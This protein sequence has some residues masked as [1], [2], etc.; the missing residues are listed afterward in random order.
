MLGT[1]QVKTIKPAFSMVSTGDM[2]SFPSGSFSWQCTLDGTRAC[3]NMERMAMHKQ[4]DVD[5]VEITLHVSGATRHIRLPLA[6]VQPS[7]AGPMPI[8]SDI[9][10]SHLYKTKPH[11]RHAV[12][13][14]N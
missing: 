2:L 3:M 6:I 13:Q 5:S 14:T 4:I 7:P 11:M 10:V 12:N 1:E 8:F 9:L